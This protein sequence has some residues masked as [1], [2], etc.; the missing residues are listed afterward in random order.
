[1]TLEEIRIILYHW[2][3]LNYSSFLRGGIPNVCQGTAQ[4]DPG[5]GTWGGVLWKKRL[6]S[7]GKEIFSQN[8]C[9]G[10]D[11]NLP[12]PNLQSL[13]LATLLGAHPWDNDALQVGEAMEGHRYQAE[14]S[15]NL[16]DDGSTWE[17]GGQCRAGWH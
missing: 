6:V 8:L 15:S 1:M 5:T 11:G 9:S 7:L 4:L 12:E 3:K 13:S 17:E 16:S 10:C 2:K 14:A